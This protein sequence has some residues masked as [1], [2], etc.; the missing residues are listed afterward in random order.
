MFVY[1]ICTDCGN[2]KIVETSHELICSNCG[3]VLQERMMSEA[4]EWRYYTDNEGNGDPSRVGYSE[5]PMIKNKFVKDICSMVH[6]QLNIPEKVCE[7]GGIIFSSIK[8]TFKGDQRLAVLCSCIYYAQREIQAGA[9]T[10][11][12]IA[13]AMCIN[14]NIMTKACVFVKEHLF[15]NDDTKHLVTFR[16]N[17]DDTL[18][19]LIL[20]VTEIPVCKINEV[21]RTVNKLYDRIRSFGHA[22]IQS[23]QVE[24]LNTT[25]IYMACKFLKINLTMTHISKCCDISIATLI[26]TEDIIK[27]ILST[28]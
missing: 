25:L 5:K 14:Q 12:E 6:I 1:P 2:N 28:K 18:Y 27:Q 15:Q 8:H 23:M 16:E 3:L 17:K 21:K 7:H 24:K 19:R 10:K 22:K 4:P 9:R 11:Q 26:K 20:V 13:T